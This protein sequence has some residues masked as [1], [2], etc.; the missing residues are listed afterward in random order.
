MPFAQSRKQVLCRAE[1]DGAA[2]QF[3]ARWLASLDF[4]PKRVK[5]RDLPVPLV[6]FGGQADAERTE[7]MYLGFRAASQPSVV[8]ETRF[9]NT[10]IL[11]RMDAATVADFAD[12]GLELQ[13]EL[14]GDDF[15]A[16]GGMIA[17]G[18]KALLI[19]IRNRF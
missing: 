9:G 19:T 10:S 7:C 14:R 11:M 13:T 15:A 17:H 3:N 1:P 12:E 8:V 16:R 6:C 2:S 4:W 18:R 5:W